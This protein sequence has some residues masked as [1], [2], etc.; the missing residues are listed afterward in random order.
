MTIDIVLI[1]KIAGAVLVFVLG[2]WIGLGMPGT[3]RPKKPRAWQASDRLR[4]TWINRMFFRGGPPSRGWDTGRLL[5]PKKEGEESE[6]EKHPV[7]RLR[8]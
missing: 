3:G 7:V 1:A 6:E 8:R 4:A 2:L 5:V